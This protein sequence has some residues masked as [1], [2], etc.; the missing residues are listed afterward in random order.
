MSERPS[1]A[2]WLTRA[3]VAVGAVGTL[4]VASAT[5]TGSPAPKSYLLLANGN[6]LPEGLAQQ[7]QAAGGSLTSSLPEVG[8]AF[9]TSNSADFRGK[10]GNIAGLASVN[11][12]ITTQWVSPVQAVAGPSV[13]FGSPPASG[14]DDEF[15]DLQWGHDAIDA[16]EAWDAGA[17]GD[18]ARVAVIDTGF[19]TDHPDLAPNVNFGL[20]ANFVPG[21]TLTYAINDPFSHG[22][23]TAGTVAAADNGFGTIGVAPEAELVLVKG[24]PDAGCGSDAPV[25]QGIVHAAGVADADVINMSLGA[26]LEKSG[27][28]EVGCDPGPAD[29]VFVTASEVTEVRK[30][31][32]RVV[33]F[34]MGQGATVIAAAGNDG[35][36]KDHSNNAIHLP[37]DTPGVISVAATAPQ[38]WGI[39]PTTD[40][41]LPGSVL[42]GGVYTNFG[43]SAIDFA[44]PGGSAVLTLPGL[45]TVGIVTNVCFA[46]DFVFSTGSNLNPAIATYY[47]SVG[48]SMAAPH[49]AGVAAIIVGEN[50]GSMSPAHVE[51]VLRASAD[52]LGKPGNDDFY[53]AGRVNAANAV[54]G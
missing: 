45:C 7:V 29:D 42:P 28:L 9:A 24:L 3:A 21:E 48:T 49:V 13:N 41:D 5:A 25:L 54:G 43:Q 22:S 31:W 17:R 20:S 39:D 16:P 23:H 35:E 2:L 4:L 12:S 47:W 1:R 19:D 37:A 52:D 38:G 32:A 15:F 36:D 40:L 6:S 10:A 34:A 50:G 27:Y 18:G 14:D 44:A 30:A 8:I 33:G 11:H 46:F 51:A 53:G 26:R